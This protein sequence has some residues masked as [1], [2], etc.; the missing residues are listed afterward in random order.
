MY[1]MINFGKT[2][3]IIQMRIEQKILDVHPYAITPPKKEGGRWQTYIKKDGEKR[4]I[5]RDSDYEGLLGQLFDFYFSG[6]SLS[7]L[8]LQSIFDEWLEY[9]STITDSM[10][11]IRRHEQHWRKYFQDSWGKM[12]LKHFD[13]LTLQ[14]MC[15][16]LVKERALTSK[17][18]QNV[19]T[20]LSGMFW[21]ASEKGYIDVNPMES[22]KITVKFRQVNKKSGA[23]ETFVTN[24]YSRLLQYLEEKWTATADPVYLAL[25]LDLYV[26]LRVGELSALK[27]S[28]LIG[29]K[30]LHI[31]REEVKKSVRTPDGWQDVYEVVEHTKTHTDRIVPLVPSAISILNRLK[32]S[33]TI[34]NIEGYI[35]TR[36]GERITS[37]QITYALEQ[38]CS[39]LQIDTKRTH[40]IRKT[41]ASRLNAGGVPL[42]AIREILGHSTT[43]TTLGYIYNPLTEKETY[44]KMAK[45]L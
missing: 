22:I 12:K 14:Q 42:D 37:R 10:N 8:P 7:N 17:E 26:G 19:K 29:L 27:W 18:W 35:F 1:D 43:T 16:R 24:E 31:C 6:I 30:S 4:K 38:A 36:N 33:G 45:A 5:I 11:T 25:K 32:V 40:K 39:H 23:Q 34:K 28:D 15:N 13:K 9:K 2:S 3:L 41:V 20:I 21:Y 44:E